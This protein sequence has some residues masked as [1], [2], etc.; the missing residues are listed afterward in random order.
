[1][2]PLYT[3]SPPFARG[4]CLDGPVANGGGSRPS[5]VRT[6][7]ISVNQGKSWGSTSTTRK[8]TT[9]LNR[10]QWYQWREADWHRRLQTT[11]YHRGGEWD[12]GNGAL[13]PPSA[14]GSPGLRV[15]VVAPGLQG[16]ART[17]L[18]LPPQPK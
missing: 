15:P 10:S 3:V 8:N 16:L 9:G 14:Q 2:P 4:A 6:D 17:P 12:R 13:L 18:L 7:H 5:S 11:K 1:M